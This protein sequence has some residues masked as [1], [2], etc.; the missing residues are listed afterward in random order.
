MLHPFE[1]MPFLSTLFSTIQPKA[2]SSTK[3]TGKR[4]ASPLKED[5]IP[6]DEK[7][8]NESSDY[9]MEEIKEASKALSAQQEEDIRM[10]PGDQADYDRDSESGDSKPMAGQPSEGKPKSKAMPKQSSIPPLKLTP[11]V[12]AHPSTNLDKETESDNL[13]TSDADRPPLPRRP[14]YK[15]PPPSIDLPKAPPTWTSQAHNPAVDFP[16]KDDDAGTHNSIKLCRETTNPNP[17]WCNKFLPFIEQYYHES[18]TLHKDHESFRYIPEH[19]RRE[20]ES[21]PCWLRAKFNNYWE[22]TIHGED[23]SG[24]VDYMKFIKRVYV[25]CCHIND[26][27]DQYSTEVIPTVNHNGRIDMDKTTAN[28]E[29]LCKHFKIHPSAAEHIAG[30]ILWRVERM[31]RLLSQYLRHN[32]RKGKECKYAIKVNR[33]GSCEFWQV[34]CA[35]VHARNFLGVKPGIFLMTVFPTFGKTR[36]EVAFV[37]PRFDGTYEER[38]AKNEIV[39]RG[40]WL[41]S[42]TSTSAYN[43]LRHDGTSFFNDKDM[44]MYVRCI[45]GHSRSVELESIGR[46]L[47][48]DQQKHEWEEPSY[49]LPGSSKYY[50]NVDDD[51]EEDDQTYHT[52]HR[53]KPSSYEKEYNIVPFSKKPVTFM[54]HS[55]YGNQLENILK[56]GLEPGRTSTPR[57]RQHVHMACI[58]DIFYDDEPIE[59]ALTHSP[60]GRDALLILAFTKDNFYNIH[61]TGERTALTENTID[62]CDIIAA[63]DSGGEIV[64]Q[65]Y[66]LTKKQLSEDDMETCATRISEFADQFFKQVFAGQ[67]ESGKESKIHSEQEPSSETKRRRRSAEQEEDID[68]Q[69]T[70]DQSIVPKVKTEPF[71]TEDIVEFNKEFRKVYLSRSMSKEGAAE[72]FE[73]IRNQFQLFMETYEE[74]P[75]TLR[76]KMSACEFRSLAHVNPDTNYSNDEFYFGHANL[77]LLWMNSGQHRTVQVIRSGFPSGSKI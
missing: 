59:K 69:A 66:Y 64:Q 42:L 29:G 61:L 43:A 36:F 1:D 20:G 76:K 9:S 55:T 35:I 68:M 6:K 49:E 34:L 11:K 56:K 47:W 30:L 39:P 51:D 67:G 44:E 32:P 13:R 48:E 58:D 12:A 8:D 70:E 77:S 24:Q 73:V 54:F 33:D 4:R 45:G 7:D 57:G 71:N 16:R 40:R 50:E 46:P 3:P 5:P 37:Y 52:P 26:N 21:K 31:S 18:K 62:T 19:L 65:H 38:Q 41:D 10:D 72:E 60:K 23:R 22:P 2:S 74:D 75:E 63:F 15:A 17:F 28:V 14:T 25:F 53:S 27:P